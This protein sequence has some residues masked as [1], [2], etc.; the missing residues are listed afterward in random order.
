MNI[1]AA[2]LMLS[3]NVALDASYAIYCS[4]SDFVQLTSFSIVSGRRATQNDQCYFD[5]IFLLRP[6][7]GILYVHKRVCDQSASS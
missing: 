1:V 6:V 4:F 5:A 3:M 2:V 7:T